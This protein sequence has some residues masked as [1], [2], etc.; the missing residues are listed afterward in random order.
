MQIS[1]KFTGILSGSGLYKTE[2]KSQAPTRAQTD[3][4]AS[5]S[6]TLS[7]DALLLSEASRTAQETPDVRQE[8]VEALRLKV[9]NGTYQVDGLRLARNLVREEPGLFAF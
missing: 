6:V 5:D 9:Q 3:G 2:K 1:S 4:G 7:Q 8:K